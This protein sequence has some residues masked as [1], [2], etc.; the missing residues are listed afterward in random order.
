VRTYCFVRDGVR[1]AR[2]LLVVDIVAVCLL[3]VPVGIVVWPSVRGGMCQVGDETRQADRNRPRPPSSASWT[4]WPS[5]IG[6]N[7]SI[8][9]STPWNKSICVVCC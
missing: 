5:L 3:K 4:C 7:H 2:V 8:H 6:V 9:I 1:R